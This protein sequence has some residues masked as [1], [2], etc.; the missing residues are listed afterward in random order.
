MMKVR[1]FARQLPMCANHPLPPL[2]VRQYRCWGQHLRRFLVF[3]T[4]AIYRVSRCF[5]EGGECSSDQVV[6]HP[7]DDTMKPTLVTAT[8]FI[9]LLSV[10]LKVEGID[11]GEVVSLQKAISSNGDSAI[12]PSPLDLR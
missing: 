11:V 1:Q 12:K 7:A 10:F 8:Y 5:S 4:E 2:V 6:V 3:S 9:V